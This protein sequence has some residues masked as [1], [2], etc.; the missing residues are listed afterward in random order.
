M[1]RTNTST[2]T[3]P[4]AAEA[5]MTAKLEPLVVAMQAKIDDAVS[6]RNVALSTA[7]VMR[8]VSNG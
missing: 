5:E 7:A 3:P 1:D 6:R 4:R 8:V 2:P